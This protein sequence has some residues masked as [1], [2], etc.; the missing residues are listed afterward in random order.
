MDKQNRFRL[1][2]NLQ[3]FADEPAVD[4]ELEEVADPSQNKEVVA[5]PPLDEL[6]PDEGADIVDPQEKPKQS[7]EMDKAFA[8]LR[9]K[10]EA[11]EQKAAAADKWAKDNYG[12]LGVN[13]WEEYQTALA[14][15]QKRKEYEDQGIDYDAVRKIAKEE[16]ENHPDVK[17]AQA[18]E[19]R[20]A[21]NGEIRAL[22]VAYPDVDIKEVDDLSDL[23][24][25]LEKLPNWDEI[26]KKVNKGYELK[27]AFEL[28]N[29]DMIVG[30]SSAAA[31]QAAR[32]N[33]RS[34]DHLKPSGSNVA[35]DATMID[36]DTM[37]MFKSMFPNKTEADFIAWKKKQNMSKR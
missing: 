6:V 35:D 28:A 30:K 17:K 11:A 16:A 19:Q 21:V 31:A 4:A 29:R 14:E 2:L 3:L 33:A 20:H 23:S 12:H 37:A 7:P 9:R 32:N 15:D 8:D 24:A 27:D 25:V 36:P 26:A 22:K 18:I 5:D 10:A 1:P 13:N 34:K